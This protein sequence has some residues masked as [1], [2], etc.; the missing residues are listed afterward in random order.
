MPTATQYYGNITMNKDD[1]PRLS[2]I[3]H[4]DNSL[5]VGDK[6]KIKDGIIGVTAVDRG[7]VYTIV[8]ILS[9]TPCSI[10][11][12]RSDD[13]PCI[14]LDGITSNHFDT[15]YFDLIERA[16]TITFS[17]GDKLFLPVEDDMH[18]YTVI[19]EEQHN[20]LD[21]ILVL[22]DEGQHV[23]LTKYN[24]INRIGKSW[25]HKPRTNLPEEL[26]NL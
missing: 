14:Q 13:K 3:S 25:I 18:E 5:Y 17:K 9:R 20:G 7:K 10:F 16:H 23:L 4:G 1:I 6:V 22:D 21:K 12:H 24:V 2:K 26:F 19:G 15:Q 8:D 11:T